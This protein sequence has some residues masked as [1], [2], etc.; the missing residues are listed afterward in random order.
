MKFNSIRLMT[1]SNI[2]EVL[3]NM[4]AYP[5]SDTTVITDM[6]E[7]AEDTEAI[8]NGIVKLAT[9]GKIVRIPTDTSETS[10]YFRITLL[11]G[12][13]NTSYLKIWF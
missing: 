1:D 12:L 10:S 9:D 11:D 7:D 8:Y 5:L 4:L 3:S 6:I 2:P 13:N